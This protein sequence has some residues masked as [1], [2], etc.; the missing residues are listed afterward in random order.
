[1][2]LCVLGMIL[3]SLITRKLGAISILAIITESEADKK[4][5]QD[6]YSIW[7][8]SLKGRALYN[9]IEILIKF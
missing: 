2:H 7:V 1:M 9:D 3:K 8:M 4:T 6:R 5:H